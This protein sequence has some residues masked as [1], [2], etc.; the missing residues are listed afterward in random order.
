MLLFHADLKV[1]DLSIWEFILLDLAHARIVGFPFAINVFVMQTQSSLLARVKGSL[2]MGKKKRTMEG[3]G[4]D[5]CWIKM[6]ESLWLF[7]WLIS[8]AVGWVMVVWR[9]RRWVVLFFVGCFKGLREVVF[10][11][12]K[13]KKIGVWVEFVLLEKVQKYLRLFSFLENVPPPTLFFDLIQT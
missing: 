10:A 2:F 8:W 9:W 3:G 4:G 11:S 12:C 13:Q 7:G 1:K 6:E 5:V